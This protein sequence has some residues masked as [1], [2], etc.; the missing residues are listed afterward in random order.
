PQ[1]A[2]PSNTE[3]NP[4]EQ[5]NLITTRSRLTTTE[6]SI[7]P[8]VHPSPRVRVEKELE[9]LI[10][11][12]HITSPASTAHVLP[13]RIQLALPLKPNLMDALTQIPKYHKVL[14]DLLKDKEKLVELANILIKVECSAIVLNKVLEKLKDL[15]KLLIPCVLQD[16]KVC[17]S[18]ADSRATINLMPLSIYE[19]LRIEPLKPTQMNLE[20]GNRSVTFPMGIAED[21]IVKVEKF[22]FLADFI[23]FDLEV[24][25]RVP[26]ILGRP[27]LRTT[28]ALVDLYEEK[29]TLR[30]GKE[31]VVFYTDKSSINNSRDIQSLPSADMSD[32][33][34]KEFADELAHIISPSDYDHF[35]FNLEDDPGELTSID[36]GRYFIRI[37]LRRSSRAVRT[38]PFEVAFLELVKLIIVSSH[39]YP[40]QVLVVTPLDNLEF[41]DSD[42]S[43]LRLHIAS[44]LPVDSKTI[45]L[46]TPQC[47]LSSNTEPNPREKVNSITTRSRLTTTEPSIPPHVHP[48]PR[49]RVEKELETLIDEVHITSP[50][51]TAHVP[52]PRIQLAL[53]LKPNL[54][55]A[56]TQ[57]PKYHKVLKDLLK[58]KEKLVELAN[59]LINVECSAIVLN[60]VLKKLKD[61]G[62]L[63]I[64][65][66][67]QDLKVCNSLA[68]SGATINL[69]PL[70][71]YE[72]L[73]IE[74]L[75]PIRMNLE[76]GNRSVTFPMGIAED[77]IA[78]V[79]KFNFLADFIIFDLEV[80]PRVPI[81]LGR[82]FLRTTKSL[83]DLYEEKLTLRGGKE[84][85]VFYTDKSSRNNSRDIQS[86][87]YIN[88][89]NFSKDK[90]ISGSTTC[91]SNL[92]LPSY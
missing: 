39:R 33:Y 51:S 65:C 23:I 45:E 50:A 40:I 15:G 6:P 78:K 76:L 62:K 69:M 81:I 88:I 26:I 12:V 77:V 37:L 41:S 44:R 52:P 10:D 18:L 56:L 11:E 82:P 22:N 71:I 53:P 28:K 87:H 54:M 72:K 38:S 59:I 36:Y 86:V 90:L 29:L 57:I 5:V 14:K 2:L 67:L 55:D 60:K 91:H 8:H 21:V 47:A 42:D 13:P 16:L 64:P 4:R 32:F 79:E 43:T 73:G 31:E 66:V 92:S 30:G 7:P 25:P 68:D 9:T 75:K 80:D 85:V 24:D 58:D 74:P 17:N 34:H 19:K 48:S 63:L 20:L 70:S 83:M 61:P 89:I 27:F 1:C 46:L 35:Y 3:P 49:V 84:E